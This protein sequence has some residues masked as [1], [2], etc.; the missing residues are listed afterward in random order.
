[1]V[2]TYY[3]IGRL[4]V[5]NEQNGKEKAKYGKETLKKLSKELTSEFGKG[6]SVQNLD[7][8]RVFYKIYSKSS[9]VSRKFTLSW[10][11]YVFLMRKGEIERK[12][13]EKESEINNWSLRDL[14]RQFNIEEFILELGKGFLFSGRKEKM[15]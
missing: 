10:S 15:I 13:Y 8:M 9:T 1:M 12:F 7:R 14:K 6:F 4:I 11:H 5:E 2:Y 3:N